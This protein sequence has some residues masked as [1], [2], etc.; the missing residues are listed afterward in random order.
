MW[1]THEEAKLSPPTTESVKTL[2]SRE[3]TALLR[4]ITKDW[5]AVGDKARRCSG[6]CVLPNVQSPVAC[7]PRALAASLIACKTRLRRNSQQKPPATVTMVTT[8]RHDYSEQEPLPY[9]HSQRPSCYDRS[10][11]SI[12]P[13]SVMAPREA[14]WRALKCH[15]NNITSVH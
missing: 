13:N 5:Q 8:T 15:G 7:P 14:Q 2:H 11:V 4:T 10:S 1:T 3:L 6:C 12:F 9:L